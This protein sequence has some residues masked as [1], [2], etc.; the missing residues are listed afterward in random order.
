MHGFKLEDIVHVPT[1]CTSCGLR[2]EAPTFQQI[3][4]DKEA[5]LTKMIQELGYVEILCVDCV[6]NM[7][8]TKATE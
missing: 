6:A 3:L 8:T 5:V 4:A 7:E 1:Q 2:A